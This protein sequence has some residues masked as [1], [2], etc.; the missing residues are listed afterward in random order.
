MVWQ[1]ENSSQKYVFWTSLSIY[2]SSFSICF[3]AFFH[4]SLNKKIFYLIYLLEDFIFIYLF[5]YWGMNSEGYKIYPY[6]LI[7]N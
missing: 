6:P 2:T 4:V 5:I 1:L 7:N 3:F